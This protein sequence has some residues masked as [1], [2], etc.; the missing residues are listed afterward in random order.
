MPREL[1]KLTLDSD[2][3]RSLAAIGCTL[4]EMGYVLGCDPKTVSNRFSKEIKEGM[5][6]LKRS[7]RHYQVQKA[8]EGNVT[9]M[10][11]L[12]KQYLGQS[13]N[14]IMDQ[15]DMDKVEQ[16]KMAFAVPEGF[17]QEEFDKKLEAARGKIKESDD[18]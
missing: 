18:E 8:F 2:G 6:E 5:G 13:E 11:W 4:T 17:S 10:I 16:P 15:D 9:M 12:G 1:K 3:V 7:L 14:P